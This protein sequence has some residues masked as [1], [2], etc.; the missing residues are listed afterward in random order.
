MPY[1]KALHLMYDIKDNRIIFSDGVGYDRDE[2]PLLKGRTENDLKFIHLLKTMFNG[3]I[4][5]EVTK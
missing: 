2:L 3:K 5:G 1:S 4:I